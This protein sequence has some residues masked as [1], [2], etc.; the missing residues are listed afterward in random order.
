MRPWH[1]MPALGCGLGFRREAAAA[2]LAA[3]DDI[4]VVEVLADAYLGG[5][6][7][8][9]AEVGDLGTVFA[10]LPHG[11]SLSL[12]S[13]D[14]LADERYLAELERFVRRFDFPYYS[15]HF[16]FT[17]SGGVGVGHLSP[18]WLTRA[19]LR[20]FCRNVRAVQSLLGRSLVL[21]N[22][23]SPLLLPGGQMSEAGFL[24]ETV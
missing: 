22:I 4:P 11:V 10:L 14:F 9:W 6:R 5:P 23:A 7:R 12:A 3:C 21:E 16:A 13:T 20:V 2:M 17:K 24:N 18:V 1:R 15:E 8:D 19:Q